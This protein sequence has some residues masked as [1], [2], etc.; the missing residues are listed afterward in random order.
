M[1][2]AFNGGVALTLEALVQTLDAYVRIACVGEMAEGQV[3]WISWHAV[4][5]PSAPAPAVTL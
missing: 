3:G 5:P 1:C 4:A 2:N